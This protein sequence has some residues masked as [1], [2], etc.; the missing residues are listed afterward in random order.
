MKFVLQQRMLHALPAGAPEIELV[1]FVTW[2]KAK[3]LNFGLHWTKE[4]VSCRYSPSR[5]F[6]ELT[7]PALSKKMATA[8]GV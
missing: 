4:L 6:A 5:W 8:G 3:T 2:P 1:K 7:H